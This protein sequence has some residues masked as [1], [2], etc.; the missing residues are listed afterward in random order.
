VLQ[1]LELTADH[2]RG[3]KFYRGAGCE[4]C[5][6]TGYKG[7]QGLFELMMMTNEMR[8]MIMNNAQ[9]EDL[10]A[11]AMKQGMVSLRQA[12]LNCCFEGTTTCE[13]VIRETILE[14]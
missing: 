12:G 9:T 6:N 1:D 14:A 13:E 11:L 2:I 4:I 10:R 3:K 8:D 5:N 7:R